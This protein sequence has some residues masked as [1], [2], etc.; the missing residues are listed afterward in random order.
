[1]M[2]HQLVEPHLDE[3]KQAARKRLKNLRLFLPETRRKDAA[4]RLCLELASKLQSYQQILSFASKKDEID[5]SKLNYKLQVEKRL[6]L[7]KVA[8]EILEVYAVDDLEKQLQMSNLGI[9]E[10]TPESCTKI[11]LDQIDCI[12]VPGLGFDSQMHRIGYGKGHYDRFLKRVKTINQKAIAIGIGFQE[13]HVSTLLP[14]DDH[15]M[16]LDQVLYY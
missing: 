3:D 8:G 13:Q 10:P 14:I 6:L 2:S 4:E 9:F 1:M 7:P 16:P 15:D 5:L 11:A 12:L